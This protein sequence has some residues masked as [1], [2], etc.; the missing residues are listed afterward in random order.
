MRADADIGAD[1]KN[2]HKKA[3]IKQAFQTVDKARPS[4]LGSG[5]FYVIK[6]MKHQQIVV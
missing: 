2:S 1:N 5:F 4:N 6:H 3:C